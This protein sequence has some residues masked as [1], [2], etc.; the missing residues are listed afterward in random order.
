[1]NEV[2]HTELVVYW[3]GVI[4]TGIVLA[5]AVLAWILWQRQPGARK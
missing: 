2:Y 5:F 3:P 1:M 4:V